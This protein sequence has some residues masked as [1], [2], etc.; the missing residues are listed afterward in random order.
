[1]D[2]GHILALD[3]PQRLKEQIGAERIL[4]LTLTQPERGA[5]QQAVRELPGV[6]SVDGEGRT[7]HIYART[8]AGVIGQVVNAVAEC[9]AELTDLAVIEPS[10]EAVYLKLT[11]REYRE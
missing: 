1:M 9:G 6:A 2:H 11:G 8:G 7:L 4:T 3:T 5:V 10:L